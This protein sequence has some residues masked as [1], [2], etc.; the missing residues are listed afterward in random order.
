MQNSLTVKKYLNGIRSITIMLQSFTFGLDLIHSQKAG[1]DKLTL[2]A[3]ILGKAHT[4]Q[5]KI[6]IVIMKMMHLDLQEWKEKLMDINYLKHLLPLLH[7]HHLN[8]LHLHLILQILIRNLSILQNQL[9]MNQYLTDHQ[10]KIRMIL[11]NMAM[12]FG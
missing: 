1:L 2:L 3:L 4:E 10:A 6:S 9:K 12:D 11:K 5:I 7:Q 8:Q